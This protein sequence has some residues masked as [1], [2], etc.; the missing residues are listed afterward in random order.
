MRPKID[1][2]YAIIKVAIVD[3][4]PSIL[5]YLQFLL[6]ADQGV[7]LVGAFDTGLSAREEIP[8]LSPQVAIVDLV[9]QPA[10]RGDL[11]ITTPEGTATKLGRLGS[12]IVESINQGRPELLSLSGAHTPNY[13]V[14]PNS[15]LPVAD[16]LVSMVK[17]GQRMPLSGE[18]TPLS[19]RVLVAGT[20]KQAD[21]MAQD[22]RVAGWK[23]SAIPTFQNYAEV[24]TLAKRIDATRIVGVMPSESNPQ[25]SLSKSDDL[26]PQFF[27]DDSRRKAFKPLD[28]LDKFGSAAI[29]QPASYQL[30]PGATPEPK[31]GGAILHT[32]IEE[33]HINVPYTGDMPGMGSGGSGGN[34]SDTKTGARQEGLFCPFLLFCTLTTTTVP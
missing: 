30:P 26:L 11:K 2:A 4:E 23:V 13:W 24:E 16:A 22:L 20:G 14:S 8:R 15:P 12:L 29:A 17:T 10:S 7:Q 1:E 6:D 21:R 5:E 9:G 33:K 25:F 28:S 18:A 31:A 3:D 34:K 32:D 19:K 27:S